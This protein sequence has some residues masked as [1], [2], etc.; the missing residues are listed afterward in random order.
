M[1]QRTSPAYSAGWGWTGHEDPNL[2]QMMK[3]IIFYIDD[4]GL[5]VY[6]V[7]SKSLWS[8]M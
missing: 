6:A 2:M 4:T 5:S 7:S 1:I 3:L 8:C